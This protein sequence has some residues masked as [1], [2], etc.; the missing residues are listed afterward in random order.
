MLS[1][2][3]YEADKPITPLK[4]S[5]LFMTEFAPMNFNF[6]QPPPEIYSPTPHEDSNG[7]SS[8][9][10]SSEPPPPPPIVIC[11]TEVDNIN[12]TLEKNQQCACKDC[13]KLFNSVW[14]LKQ[15]AV[16]HSNDRPFKC[17][18][19]FKTYKFRS[20]LYQHKCPDRQ[21]QMAQVGRLIAIISNSA[22]LL[23][24]SSRRRGGLTISPSAR[25]LE[26]NQ[27][28]KSRIEANKSSDNI[29]AY[30]STHSDNE[31]NDVPITY[32]LVIHKLEETPEN[33]VPVLESPKSLSEKTLTRSVIKERPPD[34]VRDHPLTQE[35]IDAFIAKNK[36]KEQGGYK[37]DDWL[38]TCRK[39]RLTFPSEASLMRHS[40]A[41]SREDMFPYKCS[42]CR[43]AFDCDRGLRRH[44][45]VHADVGPRRC[46]ECF[47]IF[48]RKNPVSEQLIESGGYHMV[49]VHSPFDAFSFIPSESKGLFSSNSSNRDNGNCYDELS[50]EYDSHNRSTLPLDVDPFDMFASKKKY[51][52]DDE[53]SGFRSRVNSVT[54]SCSPASSSTF[55]SE[56][57]SPRRKISTSEVADNANSYT[58]GGYGTG[59]TYGQQLFQHFESTSIDSSTFRIRGK[60][61]SGSL[62]LRGLDFVPRKQT[63]AYDDLIIQIPLTQFV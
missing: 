9:S 7:S 56:G 51:K 30:Q 62:L 42:C 18:F 2:H 53:D 20:N 17:K 31:D 21:K 49:S 13:G 58:L 44:S 57:G 10:K 11:P 14:Y 15:H 47:G 34:C 59:P 23:P 54:Q 61:K 5:C 3:S 55:S 38:H 37:Q 33:A 46:E 28:L 1:I 19:C 60:I 4:H 40:A 26:T 52:E 39:C 27:L 32:G 50:F 16:K 43:Q 63:C 22:L 48:S 12:I 25:R 45:Q 29:M 6:F 24:N 41:H 36:A 35:E 8:A